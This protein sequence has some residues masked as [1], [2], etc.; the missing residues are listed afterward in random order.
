MAWD[1]RINVATA[2]AAIIPRAHVK[3][4]YA[5]FFSLYDD[6]WAEEY[7]IRIERLP[8]CDKHAQLVSVLSELLDKSV[9]L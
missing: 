8:R 5:A 3:A 1:T 2:M 7:M 6:L 4:A 9:S